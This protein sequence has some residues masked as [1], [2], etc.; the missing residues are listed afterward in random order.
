MFDYFVDADFIFVESNHDLELLR[1]YY[2]PN[3]RFHMPNPD[4]AELLVNARSESSKAPHMVM[5]GHLSSQRNKAG[6]ALDQTRSAFQD[7][8]MKMDFELKAAPLRETGEV[9]RIR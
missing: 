1:L 7:A 5:L 9:V 2:N 4:T 6:I 8:G 3:S